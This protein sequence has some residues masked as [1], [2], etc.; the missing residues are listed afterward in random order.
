MDQII[1]KYLASIGQRGGRKSRRTLSS[2]AAR[3][4]VRLREARRAFS[5]FKTMCFWSFKADLKIELKDISWVTEQL[6]KHGNQEAW[7]VARR[8]CP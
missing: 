7:E 3:D 6:M 5:H 2:E 8:L 4:M 1:S